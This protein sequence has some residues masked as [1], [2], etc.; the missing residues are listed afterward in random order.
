MIKVTSM[1]KMIAKKLHYEENGLVGWL[2]C[3]SLPFERVFQSI[4]SR[5]SE[6]GKQKRGM[7]GERKISKQSSPASTTST[8]SAH[9]TVAA[10]ALEVT[11]HHRPTIPIQNRER[12]LSFNLIAAFIK[13]FVQ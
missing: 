5:L 7:I 12:L 2:F 3:V 9:P 6:R 11:Q 13:F 4:E 10:P 8:V 1:G